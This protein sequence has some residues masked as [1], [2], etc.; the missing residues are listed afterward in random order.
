MLLPTVYVGLGDFYQ[1]QQQ[2][3]NAITMFTKVIQDSAFDSNYR[4]AVRYLINV[5]DRLG[6]WDRGL[7]PA[8][9]YINRF[10]DDEMTFNLR[11]KIGVFLMNLMQFDD[12]IVYFRDQAFCRRRN[13][14]GNPV[15]H[16]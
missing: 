2:W 7:G 11:V 3:D 14:A 5:Y 8:R 16:W 9:H 10:P 12:A 15:L 6:L 1:T 13:R 4:L